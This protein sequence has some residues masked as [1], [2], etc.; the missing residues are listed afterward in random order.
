MH[1]TTSPRK[2]RADQE[3]SRY[4]FR[5]LTVAGQPAVCVISP[6]GSIYTV[7]A[8]LRCNCGDFRNRCDGTAERCKHCHMVTRFLNE[9]DEEAAREQYYAEARADRKLW[10]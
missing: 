7:N 2:Q 3:F 1:S 10:E 4:S 5:T 9:R 6:S 8:K